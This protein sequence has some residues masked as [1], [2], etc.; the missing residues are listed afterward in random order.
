MQKRSYEIQALGNN[1]KLRLKVVHII[2][3]GTLIDN[4][5]CDVADEDADDDNVKD[6]VEEDVEAKE[7]LRPHVF[8]ALLLFPLNNVAANVRDV[9]ADLLDDFVKAFHLHCF[10]QN[11]FK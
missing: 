10:L 11:I 3:H 4:A 8:A 5:R 7:Q 1:M 9:D 2:E 6:E